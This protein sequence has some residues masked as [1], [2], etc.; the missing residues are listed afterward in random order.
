MSYSFSV[1]AATK[2]EAKKKIAEEW[3]NVVSQ[4]PIHAADRDSAQAFAEASVDNLNDPEGT[5]EIRVIANGS[6]RYLTDRSIIGIDGT[7]MT[8]LVSK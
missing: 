2:A 6:V 3:D 4:Q 5:Q 1:R 7:V 8:S